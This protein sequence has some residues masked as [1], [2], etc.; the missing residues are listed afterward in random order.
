MAVL[1]KKLVEEAEYAQYQKCYPAYNL[2][3]EFLHLP[4]SSFI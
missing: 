1:W 3:Y 2:P 4:N